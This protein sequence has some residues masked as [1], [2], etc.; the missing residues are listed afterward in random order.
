M[1]DLNKPLMTGNSLPVEFI[2]EVNGNLVFKRTTKAGRNQTLVTDKQGSD[3]ATGN[4][5]V[6]NKIARQYNK[7]GKKTHVVGDEVFFY[8]FGPINPKNNPMVLKGTV[9]G[10]GKSGKT[11]DVMVD[12]DVVRKNPGMRSVYR[13]F[14]THT[15]KD[16]L[17]LKYAI[18]KLV[19]DYNAIAGSDRL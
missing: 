8:R 16:K 12:G 11:L 6:T 17:H 2:K 9:I 18:T 1:L 13:P 10:D 15:F 14:V 7:G 19:N 3:L 5:L 4:S